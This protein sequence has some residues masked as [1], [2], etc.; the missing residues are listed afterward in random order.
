M[1]YF[2][3]GIWWNVIA[4]AHSHFFLLIKKFL[5]INSKLKGNTCASYHQ[6][7]RIFSNTLSAY[8][9]FPIT[10]IYVLIN[11]SIVLMW[12]SSK[13]YNGYWK[14]VLGK[15]ENSKSHTSWIR[16]S[17][18]NMIYNISIRYPVEILIDCF[19]CL[20]H[21]AYRF[22]SPNRCTQIMFCNTI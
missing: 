19:T 22:E 11:I 3:K 16:C 14:I 2:S 13:I 18:Y 10:N 4:I 6:T 12:R 20:Y 7:L 17:A 9:T 5:L 8:F 21:F 1:P 15:I